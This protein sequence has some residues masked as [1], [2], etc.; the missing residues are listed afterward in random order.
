MEKLNLEKGSRVDL[1]KTNPGLKKVHAGLGWDVKS[2][3]GA[4]FDLD[5]FAI[6][7][8][9][10]GKLLDGNKS[11]VFFGN[12]TTTGI[13]HGGDNLTGVGDGDDETVEIDLEALN[14]AGADQIILGA[15][16]YKA[17]ERNQ[18]F[19]QV[20][21]AFCRLYDPTNSNELMK[22]DLTENMSTATGIVLGRL[23]KVDG[24]WKFQAVGEG[25]AGDINVFADPYR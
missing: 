3:G 4:D 19:G 24:E 8:G 15:N 13:K 17:A 12:K 10:S 2:S 21:R 11:V 7:L 22:Y 1:T 6:V 20:N 16:I 14:T 18:N 25:K 9:A 5:A 23:Y